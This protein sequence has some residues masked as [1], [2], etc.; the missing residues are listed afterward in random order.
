MLKSI[1]QRSV[2]AQCLDEGYDFG[3][4]E[5]IYGPTYSDI[6]Q[7]NVCPRKEVTF[8]S[9]KILGLS[10]VQI[11]DSERRKSDSFW[12]MMGVQAAPKQPGQSCT[13]HYGEVA[14]KFLDLYEAKVQGQKRK[15][16]A[17]L[18]AT[19]PSMASFV[20][21]WR[22]VKDR[23]VHGEDNCVYIKA[24]TAFY[25]LG[26]MD[27]FREDVLIRGTV[28]RAD[29]PKD[30]AEHLNVVPFFISGK[31]IGVVGLPDSADAVER[32]LIVAV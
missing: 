13:I 17:G 8:E 20:W 16:E 1:L 9:E 15:Y 32:R 26:Q 27:V 4:G 22:A 31:R 2:G 10:K 18:I 24:K 7:G 11:E 6:L 12:S 19:V 14:L 28:E 23:Y 5:G 30:V 3:F 21:E 29:A 25:N